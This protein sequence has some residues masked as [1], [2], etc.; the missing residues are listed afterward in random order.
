MRGLRLGLGLEGEAV[1]GGG[2][3]P[4]DL[5][6]L[7]AWYDASDETSFTD[8]GAPDYEVSQIND[9][10]PN[11]YHVTQGTATQMPQAQQSTQNGLHVITHTTTLEFLIK[12]AISE[13]VFDGNDFYIV[14]VYKSAGV[15]NQILAHADPIIAQ[16]N[17]GISTV[18][19]ASNFGMTNITD[20]Q[21]YTTRQGDLSNEVRRD[22]AS[23]ATV[24]YADIPTANITTLQW[25]SNILKITGDKCEQIMFTGDNDD[26]VN[27][28][29]YAKAKWGTP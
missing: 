15:A 8:S 14:T 4:L 18:H 2:Y 23:V 27:V 21:L 16:Y 22:E 24:N 13:A 12:T 5:A 26:L 3:S 25:G 1:A 29:A 28:E 7:I 19:G 20:L 9:L 17:L 11:G 6:N 10:G